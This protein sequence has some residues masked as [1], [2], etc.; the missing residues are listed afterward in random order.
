[1]DQVFV[2]DRVPYRHPSI[3]KED[4]ATAWMNCIKSLPRLDKNPDEYLAIGTDG[5]GRLLELVVIRNKEG[6]WLI[7]HAVTPPTEN[8]IRELQ[9][10][11]KKKQ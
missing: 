6:D 7:Y 11:R 3:S 9:M 4:A 8:A 10:D 5:K 2:D 1:M